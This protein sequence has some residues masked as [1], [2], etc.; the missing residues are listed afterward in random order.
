[1][2]AIVAVLTAT[3]L[4]FAFFLAPAAHAG[5]PTTPQ[6]VTEQSTTSQAVSDAEI[7]LTEIDTNNNGPHSIEKLAT[8]QPGVVRNW[9][10]LDPKGIVREDGE[11]QY[12][13][14]PSGATERIEETRVYFSDHGTLQSRTI[15]DW[16]FSGKLTSYQLT[17]YSFRGYKISDHITK[18]ETEGHV[19]SS[20]NPRTYD[21]SSTTIPYTGAASPAATLTQPGNNLGTQ[22]NWNLRVDYKIGCLFPLDY[23]AGDQF[24]GSCW[25]ANYAEA[26]KTVPGLYEYTLPIK[27]YALQDGTPNWSDLEIG[28][29]GYGYTPLSS[30]GRFCVHIPK[31]WKGALQFQLRQP[32]YLNGTTP[33]TTNF[34]IGDPVASPP[35]PQ[36]L[37]P[38]SFQ[39]QI[40]YEA[41][42]HLVDL[43]NE[44]FDYEEEYRWVQAHGESYFGELWEIEDDLDDVYDEIDYATDFLPSSYIVSM[45]KRMAQR[46][47]DLNS[48]LRTN[49]LTPE[50]EIALQEYDR[51]ANF[52]DG[53]ARYFSNPFVLTT[54]FSYTPYWTSPIVSQ[55]KLGV[56]RGPFTGNPF[57]TDFRIGT[58]YVPPIGMTPNLYYFM[59]YDGLPAGENTY[60][61]D[62][63][64]MPL[65]TMP[66]DYMWMT[67]GANPLRLHKGGKTDYWV[68]LDLKLGVTGNLWKS[69]WGNSSFFPSDLVS[70]SDLGGQPMPGPGQKVT[71]TLKITDMS[72]TVLAMKNQFFTLNYGSFGSDGSFE[73]TGTGTAIADG[74]FAIQVDAHMFPMPELGLGLWPGTSSMMSEPADNPLFSRYAWNAGP[75][76]T[77]ASSVSSCPTETGS[78]VTTTPASVTTSSP[79]YNFN[80]PISHCM[81]SA[82]LDDYTA[83]TG[84]QPSVNI[85]NPPTQDEIDAARK[86]L[87]DAEQKAKS[88]NS[89]YYHIEEERAMAWRDG[90]SRTP[91][92]VQDNF[93]KAANEDVS[94]DIAWDKAFDEFMNSQSSENNAKLEAADVR[95]AAARDAYDKAT[96]DVLD[97]FT[98]KDRAAYDALINA[99]L[100]AAIDLSLANEELRDAREALDKLP[101]ATWLRYAF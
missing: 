16:D 76:T 15:S 61:I 63:P 1:L 35:L 19:E 72:P 73:T 49:N 96:K 77:S 59:P 30:D 21:W 92:D 62:S 40:D 97:H 70:P 56:I 52:L 98:P 80:L 66:F 41:A 18:Y 46:N 54:P 14:M 51:W 5:G 7:R 24:S 81:G 78:T 4:A 8:L 99:R 88:A 101:P 67:L 39:S 68:K 43:W 94:A 10:D 2:P 32:D 85:G 90:L 42:D 36:N 100:N 3:A 50:Q 75:S 53:E 83:A 58:T 37:M 95:L 34:Q 17:D 47:R 48:E 60:T 11:I 33:Y 6:V 64:G 25:K 29:K 86:R 13:T 65:T 12:G 93:M 84:G 91:Q 23:H 71:V 87:A 31:D 89:Y 79:A 28:I 9:Q 20:W 27:T 82:A 38:S 26:F 22:M 44:A 55:D 57:N 74:G 69:A 45:A